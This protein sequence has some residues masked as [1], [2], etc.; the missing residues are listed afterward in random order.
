LWQGECGL[1]VSASDS[2]VRG[3]IGVDIDR[4]LDLIRQR[5]H[6]EVVQ[7]LS[8][9]EGWIVKTERYQEDPGLTYRQ[10]G[11]DLERQHQLD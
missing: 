6:P 9:C 5:E 8:G 11:C 10:H 1:R 2:V 7:T 3:S 4:G